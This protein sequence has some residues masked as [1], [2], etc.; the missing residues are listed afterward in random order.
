MKYR[1]EYMESGRRLVLQFLGLAPWLWPAWAQADAKADGALLFGNLP[2]ET[3]VQRVFAAGFPAA[4]LVYCLVP[5][6]L[7]GWP[8]PLQEQAPA[9]L[10]L[11]QQ[12]L[13]V[14]GR[15]SG[16]GS[17]V[18]LERL[19]LLQ[20]DLVVD[21]GSVN[22]TYR[23]MAERV[24]QQTGIPY[25][26]IDGRLV[27]SAQQLREAGHLLGAGER[28]E[29]LASYA[30][31]TLAL[32]AE[33]RSMRSEQQRPRVYLARSADGLETG[34]GGAIHTEAVELVGGRNVAAGLGRGGLARVALEQVLD[35]NPDFVLTHNAQFY[36]RAKQSS[37]WQ[38]LPAVR[39]GRLHL[40]PSLPFGWLDSPP[41]VNRLLG[42]R[43]LLSLFYGD[44]ESTDL[45]AATQYFFQLFYSSSPDRA[46]LEN[47]LAIA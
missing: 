25:V 26:L 11:A 23:S 6:K 18:P 47:L 24:A 21:A 7:L 17:T 1:E 20:P 14:L 34:L 9:L 5:H 41:G 16:R 15:L 3:S 30:E 32:A 43:W 38:R 22:A 31:D 36:E 33:Q 4:V 19:M 29:Q 27:E 2:A 46:T 12:N 45:L 44:A 13:T 42:V 28:A 39:E 8:V 10:A 40:V 37:L 35:W